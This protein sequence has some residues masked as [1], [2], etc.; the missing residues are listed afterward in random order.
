MKTKTLIS[1]TIADGGIAPSTGV[2]AT[3]KDRRAQDFGNACIRKFD[4]Y[5]ATSIANR[6]HQNS[7]HDV[8]VARLGE[9]YL[10]AAEAYLQTNDA[11]NAA[12][13]INDLRKRPGTI[14]AGFETDMQVKASDMNI[15]FIL[16]E[17]AR[18]M[19]GEYVRWTDLKRT[20]K[21]IEYVTQYNED[22]VSESAMKGTDGK[23]KILRPIPQTAI[24]LNMADVEQNPGF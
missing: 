16:A 24:D 22:G 11:T 9:A 2:P 7:M 17:R 19:A 18:E 10:I 14:K 15:D 8:V 1:K 4:D 21:L 3:Y 20:H 13:M 6:G 23:Y 5:T 12:K